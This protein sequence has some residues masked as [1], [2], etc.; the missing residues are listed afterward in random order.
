[1]NAHEPF[2]VKKGTSPSHFELES[3]EP[4][5]RSMARTHRN[6]LLLSELARFFRGA[7]ISTY[8]LTAP[9][10]HLPRGVPFSQI[11]LDSLLYWTSKCGLK[12]CAE[13]LVPPKDRRY[14]PLAIGTRDSRVG[15]PYL[16]DEMLSKRIDTYDCL[17]WSLQSWSHASGPFLLYFSQVF[18]PNCKKALGKTTFNDL[19]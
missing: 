16:R 10:A 5:R 19:L 9:K 11:R 2:V 6:R 8:I 17:A 1:M 18:H 13:P 7:M 14:R 12:C 4:D 3:R 15:N